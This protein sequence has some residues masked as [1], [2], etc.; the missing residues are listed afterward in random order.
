[1]RALRVATFLSQQAGFEEVYN[2]NGGIHKYAE[3]VDPSIGFY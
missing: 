2:V 3:D 1:M